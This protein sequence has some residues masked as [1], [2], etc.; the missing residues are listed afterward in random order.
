MPVH[1]QRCV[2]LRR[3]GLSARFTRCIALRCFLASP[4]HIPPLFVP[5]IYYFYPS[6]YLGMDLFLITLYLF[7]NY[8]RLM[9]GECPRFVAVSLWSVLL[10]VIVTPPPSC[11][12]SQSP[13]SRGNKTTKIR[14]L[15]YAIVLSLPL[16]T[17]HSYY[18]TL[19]TYVYVALVHRSGD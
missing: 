13:A 1:I 11:L 18:I 10:A 16:L 4:P 9:F 15:V 17:L 19:Q 6:D 14:P 5:A 2:E 3:C 8:S 12:V 7:V